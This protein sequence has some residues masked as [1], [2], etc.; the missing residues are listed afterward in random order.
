MPAIQAAGFICVL[1]AL[2]WAVIIAAVSEL[3]AAF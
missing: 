3:R 2:S 1:S